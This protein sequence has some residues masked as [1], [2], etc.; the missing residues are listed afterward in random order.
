MYIK[1]IPYLKYI[2]TIGSPIKWGGLSPNEQPPY[3]YI[4]RLPPDL[5]HS[6]SYTTMKVLEGGNIPT[7]ISRNIKELKLMD[8]EALNDIEPC[9]SSDSLQPFH[10]FIQKAVVKKN[11]QMDTQQH[12]EKPTLDIS[13]PH[14]CLLSLNLQL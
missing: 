13:L 7:L 10:R 2:G 6:V 8:K 3:D 12:Y 9:D 14:V 4:Y 5:K 11:V 1:F